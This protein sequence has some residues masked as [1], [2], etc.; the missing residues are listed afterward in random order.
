MQTHF[1]LFPANSLVSLKKKKESTGDTVCP[2]NGRKSLMC[3]SVCLFFLLILILKSTLS[4]F[5][6]LHYTQI[7]TAPLSRIFFKFIFALEMWQFIYLI[8]Y[9]V[10]QE[11]VCLCVCVFFLRE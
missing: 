6:V 4:C 10:L 5:I 1:V 2:V 7:E 9:A 3:L 8:L 11:L